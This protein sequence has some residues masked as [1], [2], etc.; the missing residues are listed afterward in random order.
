MSRSVQLVDAY[1]RP[2][3]NDKEGNS[4]SARVKSYGELVNSY[5]LSLGQTQAPVEL[6]ARDPFS[7]HV[8]VYASAMV[9]AITASSAPFLVMRETD[10]MLAQR[11]R[12][13]HKQGRVFT[14][15]AGSNRRAV[16]RH[17]Q[18]AVNKR[19]VSKAAEPDYDH[20][21][22]A[23]LRTPN[24]FQSMAALFQFTYLWLVLRG[25]VFWI[26]TD[27]NGKIVNR[28]DATQI[29][30]FSPDYFKPAFS[31]GTSGTVIGWWFTPPR[32]SAVSMPN[33]QV[34]VSFDELTQFKIG[35]P[36]SHYRGMGRLT[37]AAMSIETSL[38]TKAYNR[39]LL[40]NSGVPRGVIT[41]P[42]GMDTKQRNEFI[43]AWEQ[44]HSGEQNA[45][46]TAM[47]TGGFQYQQVGLTPED[48]QYVQ[49]EDITKREILAAM[50]TPPAVVGVTETLS[51]ATGQA[52]ENGF[53][54]RTI[55]PLQ[56][57]VESELDAT[58]FFTET[59][60]VFGMHELSK[61]D[62]LR[63]GL[64]E[65]VDI[66]TKL[67]SS[68]LHMPPSTAFKVVGLDVPEYEGDDEAFISG[69]VSTVKETLSA[70]NDVSEDAGNSIADTPV[71]QTDVSDE[72]LKGLSSRVSKARGRQREFFRLVKKM[73]SAFKKGYRQWVS[74]ERART[75]ARFD[76]ST[77]AQVNVEAVLPTHSASS[78]AL[79]SKTTK[80]ARKTQRAAFDF[81]V[82]DLTSVPVFSITDARF[83]RYFDRRQDAFGDNVS[84]T[85][86]RKLRK[87]LHDGIAEGETIQELRL[88]IAH[89]YNVAESS[90]RALLIAR[91][92]TSNMINGIRNEVFHEHGV[93]KVEWVNSGDDVVR[94]SHQVFGSA[95]PR[96][97]DFNYMTLVGGEGNLRHPGDL[98]GPVSE[99][100]NCRCTTIPIG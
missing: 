86:I 43:E 63:A 20:P 71:D 55:I 17:I 69:V 38:M 53:W 48:I 52:Q 91:T 36:L 45:G 83:E 16:E 34:P 23:K 6:R 98:D 47:L 50:G 77:K 54:N 46:Q 3:L 56:F 21:I 82:D 29:W 57:I 64:N 11:T 30:P 66:A 37:A 9:T 61:I 5:L 58:L 24:P 92:E 80:A 79:K 97:L 94:E 12:L 65:K 18:I 14:P 8:W 96:D 44:R 22:Y 89:V 49:G 72:P 42:I 74:S 73:E 39:S 78:T 88:R 99:T 33:V 13:A 87:A 32:T 84:N 67:C 62:A 15:K 95:G 40:K 10:V 28:N 51:Y 7:N 2:L 60:D 26:Y 27:D 35:S 59:D 75:L 85:V 41:Y 31:G 19:L 76:R 81:T 1:G 25:E 4:D 90:A 70:A 93:V 100:A 68:S